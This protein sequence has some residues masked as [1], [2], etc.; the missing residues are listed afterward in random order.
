[1]KKLL[2][3]LA[4]LLFAAPAFAAPTLIWEF[5]QTTNLAT[6]FLIYSQ[7]DVAGADVYNYVVPDVSARS[8]EIDETRYRPGA[9]YNFWIKAY[10]TAGTGPASNTALYTREAF[11]ATENPPPSIYNINIPE[12]SVVN[13]QIRK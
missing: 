7:E 6:G 1:M 13:I 8:F 11:V 10:N 2:A 5:T 3:V 4:I 12:N 9:N